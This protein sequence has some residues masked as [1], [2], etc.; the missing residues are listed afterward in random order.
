MT[1]EFQA[2]QAAVNTFRDKY[3]ALPGDMAN[4]EDF[5]GS[6]GGNPANCPATAGTGTETCN[7]NGD[8]DI[9]GG[10]AAASQY[11]EAFTFWQH[12]ANAGLIEGNYTGRAGAGGA[13]DSDI[14][15]NVPRSKLGNAGWSARTAHN[16]G[17]DGSAFAYDYGDAFVF[18]S[19]LGV[20]A[21]FG[22]VF[23]PEELWN[24][25]TKMDDGMPGSGKILSMLWDTCTT[26][27]NANDTSAPYDLTSTDIACGLH[28]AKNF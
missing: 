25:D 16:Y 12:L 5:W 6:P 27:A 1:T 14:A 2:F 21:T 15:V 4:A 18:G 17:G 26:A 20:D 24:I 19:E 23:K 22:A 13:Q 8:G 7:G 3:F 9:A 28:G 10:A 11:G